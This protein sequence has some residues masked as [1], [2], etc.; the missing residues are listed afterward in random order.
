MAGD[1]A[2]LSLKY[3][4]IIASVVLLGNFIALAGWKIAADRSRD[5]KAIAFTMDRIHRFDGVITA[6]SGLLVFAFGY[7]GVRGFGVRIANAPF[8]MWGLILMT[9]AGLVWYFGMRPLEV[10]MADLAEDALSKGKNPSRE[11]YRASGLWF[12]C[13]GT[14]VFLVLV[15]AALMVFKP[16][17]WPYYA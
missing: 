3:L 9:V 2:Y 15:I 4:H 14:V 13:V 6:T 16:D 17:I 5:A 12:A 8:A 1:L 10:R 11:Y 7:I